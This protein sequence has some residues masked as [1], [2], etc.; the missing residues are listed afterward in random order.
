MKAETPKKAPGRG[1][2]QVKVTATQMQAIMQAA[3]N[4]SASL[5]GMGPEAEADFAF[6]IK[7]IDR[8][9]KSNGY[10]RQYE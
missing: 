2:R 4:L 5:G 3:D 9:L 8:F 7:H 6:C 10:K 1:A